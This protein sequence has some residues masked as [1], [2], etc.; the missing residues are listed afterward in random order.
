VVFHSLGK[1]Q[2]E[3]IVRLQVARVSGR[4]ASRKISLALTDSAYAFLAEVGFDPIYGARPV[5]RA[6]Q[7]SLETLLA[8]AILRGDIQDEDAVTVD[9]EGEGLALQVARASKAPVVA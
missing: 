9:L 3:R 5:K 2:I 1:Q 7:H 4:L 8:Q 6:I